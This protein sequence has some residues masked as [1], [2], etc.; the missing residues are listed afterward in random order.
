MPV[1]KT[2]LWP[3]WQK[4]KCW[5]LP[6]PYE[7][8]NLCRFLKDRNLV[9]AEADLK[10][11]NA[12]SRACSHTH[13]LLPPEGT[14]GQLTSASNG[15]LKTCKVCWYFYFFMRPT[16]KACSIYNPLYRNSSDTAAWVQNSGTLFS[17][18]H[19]QLLLLT[20]PAAEL[21]IQ[22]RKTEYPISNLP[23]KDITYLGAPAFCLHWEEK[24]FLFTFLGFIPF[25]L[26]EKQN[27]MSCQR[28]I[29]NVWHSRRCSSVS[30]QKDT[31]N[32]IPIP[33]EINK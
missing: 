21:E 18:P 15:Y 17:S 16:L 31:H 12:S 3:A 10:A 29:L 5:P 26:L 22:R 33:G 9:D 1:Y 28:G 30:L 14:W 20:W 13:F 25:P 8:F 6:K 27:T 11:A 19:Q 32:I 23:S 7:D 24:K 2:W 4:Q